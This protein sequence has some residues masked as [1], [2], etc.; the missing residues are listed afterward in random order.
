MFS[1]NY[2]LAGISTSCAL[3]LFFVVVVFVDLVIT[4][5]YAVSL[6]SIFIFVGPRKLLSQEKNSFCNT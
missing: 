4:L 3:G 1:L 2:K 5:R 6:G